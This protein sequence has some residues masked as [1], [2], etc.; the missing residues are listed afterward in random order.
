MSEGNTG[1]TAGTPPTEPAM[2][3][4][5]RWGEPITPE[6]QAELDSFSSAGP[7]RKLQPVG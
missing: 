6:R 3:D 2:T 7:A 1:A 5:H 4:E